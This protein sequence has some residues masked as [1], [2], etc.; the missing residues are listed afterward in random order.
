MNSYTAG[1]KFIPLT[2]SLTEFLKLAI[3]E[4][5]RL[6]KLI[7]SIVEGEV[8]QI[9]DVRTSL[10]TIFDSENMDVVIEYLVKGSFGEILAKLICPEDLRS[11]EVL[12]P[13]PS[14]E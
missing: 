10:W 5:L 12:I 9:Y 4:S 1:D 3:D 11:A 13:A 14:T 7:E 8:G 6:L 2:I